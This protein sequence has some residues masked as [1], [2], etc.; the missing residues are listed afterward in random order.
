MNILSKLHTLV[1]LEDNL[2]NDLPSGYFEVDFIDNEEKKIYLKNE[3][4][5]CYE[6]NFSDINIT[7]PSITCYG[8]TKLN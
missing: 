8:L 7:D 2:V 1:L 3:D 6:V 5:N 4:N